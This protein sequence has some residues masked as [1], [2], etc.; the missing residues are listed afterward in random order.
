MFF[1]RFRLATLTFCYLSA[2]STAFGAEEETPTWKHEV[3]VGI[4]GANGNT[5]AINLHTGYTGRYKDATHGWKLKSAHDKAESNGI[6][7][8]NQFF[9]DLL[10][11]WYWNG[12]PWIAFMQGRYDWD[13]FKEWDY[14]LSA[15][16]G[17]GY[18]FINNNIWYLAGRFGLGGY[19]IYGYAEEELTAEALFTL[20][21]SW[22]ISGRESVDFETTFFPSLE[23]SGEYRNI[24]ALN[25]KMSMMERGRL[26]LK[27]GLINEYDS[28]A[29]V[30]TETND[31]K[32]NLSLVWGLF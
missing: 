24:T 9:A 8:R 3:D 30:G 31:F 20:E 14:R 18:E 1:Y 27:I 28:L 19:R 26:A 11:D 23:K 29:A 12:S 5:K 17:T 2:I 22:T 32:Y 25:W 10:K 13:E 4:N 15:S 7:T 21:A 16:G 6:E